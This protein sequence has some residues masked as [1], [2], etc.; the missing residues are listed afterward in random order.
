MILH[1]IWHYFVTNDEV[2][3][4]FGLFDVSYIIH[5]GRLGLFDPSTVPTM[6]LHVIWHYF[7]SNDEVSRRF[8]LFDVSYIICKGR[9]GLF[10]HVARLRSDA[11][12]NH[13]L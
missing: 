11:P 10:G 13:I 2:S 4:R 7:V 1:V 6:I 12:A 5:K 8:G 9:L 3:H